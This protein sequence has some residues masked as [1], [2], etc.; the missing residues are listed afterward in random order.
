MRFKRLVK[1][2]FR[3]ITVPIM[4]GPLK[5]KKWIISTSIKFILGKYVER[6]AAV[7]L[8]QV[9][10]AATVYDVGAHIGYFTLL[11][12]SLVGPQGKVIAFEPVPF[13]LLFLKKHVAINRCH[14]VT[15]SGLCVADKI[16]EDNFDDSKGSATGHLSQQGTLKVRTDSLD[17]LLAAGVI[18]PPDFIK[19][20]AEGAE[21]QVLRG[22]QSII[23]KYRPG[24][25]VTFHSDDLKNNCIR[26]LQEHK[27]Q[28][29]Q[30]ATDAIYALYKG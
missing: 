6:D 27:Y 2:A 19:I 1:S 3:W 20:N 30:T 18:T 11:C 10:P 25:L 21:E 5:G 17:H 23:E 4:G 28:V 16:G 24:F 13:N 22:C 7:L 26:M 29:H 12:S 9:K 8:E 15:V 14:N